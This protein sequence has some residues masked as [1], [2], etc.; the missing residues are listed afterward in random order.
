MN[1]SQKVCN[2]LNFVILRLQNDM[3]F[4]DLFIDD[5]QKNDNSLGAIFYVIVQ[6]LFLI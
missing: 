6:C 3:V 2:F 4:N 1:I 5:L